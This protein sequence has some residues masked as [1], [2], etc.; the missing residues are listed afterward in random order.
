MEG[1]AVKAPSASFLNK[2]LILN[3]AHTLLYREILEKMF[4]E[5]RGRNNK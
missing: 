5:A 3:Q 4:K 1:A 2:I